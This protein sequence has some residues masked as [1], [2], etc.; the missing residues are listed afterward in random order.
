MT[1]IRLRPAKGKARQA[2]VPP[3]VEGQVRLLQ[4]HRRL[5]I[6]GRLTSPST[7]CSRGRS[8]SQTDVGVRAFEV[9]SS[10]ATPNL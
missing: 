6:V 3:P 8:V 4:R 5:A 2:F 7:E 1:I 10:S 9:V